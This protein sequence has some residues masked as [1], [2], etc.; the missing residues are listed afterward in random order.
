MFLPIIQNYQEFKFKDAASFGSFIFRFLKLTRILLEKLIEV[1]QSKKAHLMQPTPKF[2]YLL[3]II[4]ITLNK[5][6]LESMCYHI[7]AL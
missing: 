1:P 7:L 4:S 6:Q 5:V 3:E 2:D